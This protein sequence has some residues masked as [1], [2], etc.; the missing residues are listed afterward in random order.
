MNASLLTLIATGKS[1]E[2]V[3]GE[4]ATTSDIEVVA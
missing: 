4:R 2:Q 3:A 1:F